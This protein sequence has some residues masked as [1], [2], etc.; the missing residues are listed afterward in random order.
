[1][2]QA[3]GVADTVPDLAC[4]VG[5]SQSQSVMVLQEL[6]SRGLAP[7]QSQQNQLLQ[8]IT[9]L[10]AQDRDDLDNSSR[11]P[12]SPTTADRLSTDVMATDGMLSQA[13]SSSTSAGL[14]PSQAKI[15]SSSI[16]VT[17]SPHSS[18][19]ENAHVVDEGDEV[20]SSLPLAEEDFVVYAS[21]NLGEDPESPAGPYDSPA[22]DNISP[23]TPSAPKKKRKGVKRPRGADE[24][25]QIL[26]FSKDDDEDDPSR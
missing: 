26:D 18:Q 8:V 17:G 13:S 23:G 5:C 21:D 2:S 15:D 12:T 9:H 6:A 11:V 20:T 7:T 22:R 16:S 3:S 10:Q 4:S 14:V 1:M 19:T 24:V 25:R